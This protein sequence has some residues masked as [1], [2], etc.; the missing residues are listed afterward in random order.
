VLIHHGTADESCPIRWSRASLR[1]LRRAG[2]DADMF[3]YPG[4]PHAFDVAWPQSMR[5]TVRFFR[6]NLDA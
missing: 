3:T 1:L 4:Q 5:R 2:V 6:R